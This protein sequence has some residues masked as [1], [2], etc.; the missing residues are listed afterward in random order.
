[1]N[2]VHEPEAPLLSADDLVEDLAVL[3]SYLQHKRTI[4]GE[5]AINLRIPLSVVLDAIKQMDWSALRTVA[6]LA[7][8]QLAL[9]NTKNQIETLVPHHR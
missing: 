4:A 3:R 7:E 6:D 9:Y 8:Q 1:M 5:Q 2:R